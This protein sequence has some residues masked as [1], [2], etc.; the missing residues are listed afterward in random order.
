[1]FPRYCTAS[2]G[3][4]FPAQN[5]HRFCPA[6]RPAILQSPAILAGSPPLPVIG[7]TRFNQVQRFPRYLATTPARRAAALPVGPS[8]TLTRID[9]GS[10]PRD[11]EAGYLPGPTDHHASDY[12]ATPGNGSMY[13][14][15]APS[16]GAVT[17]LSYAVTPDFSRC[18]PS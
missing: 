11:S 6:R 3:P 1:M 18:R 4:G 12:Q 5:N 2:S 7:A 13:I 16:G 17:P 15:T 8:H 14:R 10:V 9:P